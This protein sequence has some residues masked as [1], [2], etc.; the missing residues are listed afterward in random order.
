MNFIGDYVEFGTLLI[1]WVSTRLKRKNNK[2]LRF[3][4]FFLII[5][6]NLSLRK[7]IYFFNTRWRCN[8]KNSKFYIN[9]DISFFCYFQIR[10]NK[11]G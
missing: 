9:P 10:L 11:G 5:Y 7:W 6:E 3:T 1:N 4:P 2:L 8:K